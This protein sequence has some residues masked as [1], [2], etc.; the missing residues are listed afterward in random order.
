MALS[1]LTAQLNAFR[2]QN[3]V[4]Q[5]HI[6]Q[7]SQESPLER[8]RREIQEELEQAERYR[9]SILQNVTTFGEQLIL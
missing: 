5:S 9:A 3:L 7:I 8:M 6:Y 2:E 4:D 1:K